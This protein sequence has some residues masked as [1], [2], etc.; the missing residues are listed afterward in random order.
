MQTS[1]AATVEFFGGGGVKA[2]KV[3]RRRGDHKQCGRGAHTSVL[4]MYE[5]RLLSLSYSPGFGFR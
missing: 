3:K 2:V 4:V 1:P 5:P